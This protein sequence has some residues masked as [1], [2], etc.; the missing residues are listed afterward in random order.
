MFGHC[1]S[2]KVVQKDA[3]SI[4]GEGQPGTIVGDGCSLQEPSWQCFSSPGVPWIGMLNTLVSL[5]H[6]L[7]CLVPNS[8]ALRSL[9]CSR[10]LKE[11]FSAVL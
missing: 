1:C 5:L 4:A 8:R 9:Y 2:I 3:K 10:L 7:F 6:F 11:I